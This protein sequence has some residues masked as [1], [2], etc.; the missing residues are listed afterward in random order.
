MGK[1]IINGAS[2]EVPDGAN[3]CISNNGIIINGVK[4]DAF[5][6]TNFGGS[7]TVNVTGPIGN[8]DVSGN[9]NCEEVRG[10]VDAGGNVTVKGDVDGSIDA[11]GNVTV[12]GNASGGIDAG[13][14]CHIGTYL[15]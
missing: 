15:R 6:S 13:G 1:I 5:N 4:S 2:I 11:G 8:L 3:V 9:V 12:T 14:N 7:I 10:D